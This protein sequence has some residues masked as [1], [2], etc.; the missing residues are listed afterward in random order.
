[1]TST[2]GMEFSLSISTSSAR[3]CGM[4]SSTVTWLASPAR[5]IAASIPELPPPITAMSLPLNS[6]PSQCGQKVTPLLRY[7]CSPGTPIR[8]QW[9]PVAMITSWARSAASSPNRTVC[10]PPGSVAG[11]SS[12]ATCDLMTSIS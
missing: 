6:G 1:M 4:N 7:S 8:R 3:H 12:V 11:I 10:R 5:S 9:A 2:L